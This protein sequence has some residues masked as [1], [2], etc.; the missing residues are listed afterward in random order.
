MNRH[1]KQDANLADAAW[2]FKGF[3]AS[4]PLDPEA[5][6]LSRKLADV[7]VWLNSLSEGLARNIGMHGDP[8]IVLTSVEFEILHDG[9][10]PNADDERK[11]QAWELAG[12]L[13]SESSRERSQ[14]DP[15][16]PA[17]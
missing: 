12:Q 13:L 10:S 16:E 2:W 5:G 14:P 15:N 8:S 7:R 17:F 3:A 4:K 11:A 1:E 6:A 9:L